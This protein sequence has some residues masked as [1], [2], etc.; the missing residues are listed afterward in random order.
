MRRLTLTNQFGILSAVLIAVVGVV[1]HA[2]LYVAITLAVLYL[3]QLVFVASA[4]QKLRIQVEENEYQA[5]HDTLTRLPNR[6]LFNDRVEQAIL[7]ARRD[8][9]RFSLMIICLLYTSPSPRD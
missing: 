2:G 9:S 1:F 5:L 3:T 6:T 8:D 4:S 7:Q